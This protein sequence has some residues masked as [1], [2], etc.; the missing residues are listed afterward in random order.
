[1]IFRPMQVCLH[2]SWFLSFK[3]SL[4]NYAFKAQQSWEYLLLVL[5]Q[6]WDKRLPR[7]ARAGVQNPAM[8]FPAWCNN[9]LTVVT[10]W[11][12]HSYNCG[13][14]RKK[15]IR[16]STLHFVSNRGL[17]QSTVKSTLLRFKIH[18]CELNPRL[19]WQ[20]FAP[21]CKQSMTHTQ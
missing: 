15:I 3:V 18:G 10:I 7:G 16:S 6:P 21:N 8:R 5:R 12:H 9:H 2:E 1:M 4:A 11:L 19:C 17:P 13:V 20:F 14:N